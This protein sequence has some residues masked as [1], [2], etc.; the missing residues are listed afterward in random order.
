[1]D[2]TSPSLSKRVTSLS[3]SVEAPAAITSNVTVANVPLDALAAPVVE[4]PPKKTLFAK[5]VT[6][7][8]AP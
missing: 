1:V 7:G 2:V 5:G 6:I 8:K 3:V 4:A